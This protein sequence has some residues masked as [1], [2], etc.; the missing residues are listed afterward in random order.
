MQ[1]ERL[2]KYHLLIEGFDRAVIPEPE[3]TLEKIRSKYPDIHIQ[4]LRADL[5]AG[6]EHIFFAAR[7]AIAGYSSRHRKSK[8]LA[9]ELLL[10]ISCQRQ[11]SKAINLLGVQA[12]DKKIVFVAL[13]E[14]ERP[15]KDL[16]ADVNSIIN[17]REQDD[18]LDIC[19]S[20]K[21]ANLKEAYEIGSREIEAARLPGEPEEGVLKRLVIERSA[22]LTLEG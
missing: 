18:L 21:I 12:M 1:Q 19:S 4:L 9:M 22:L 2:D 11:I 5:I 17:G 13:A 16:A 10:Y 14:S 6:K 3:K 7:N 8:G 15:L 20:E